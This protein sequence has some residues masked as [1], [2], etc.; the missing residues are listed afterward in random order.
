MAR[1][2]RHGTKPSPICLRLA[3]M[4]QKSASVCLSS[5][6]RQSGPL[7]A[8]AQSGK[9]SI[10]RNEL[11]D[12]LQTFDLRALDDPDQRVQQCIVRHDAPHRMSV[13]GVSLVSGFRR[14]SL[15]PATVRGSQVR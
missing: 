6:A 5:A 12:A 8:F 3:I 2:T 9:P 14:I 10:W 1:Y 4:N 15:L 11:K 7:Q 13:M